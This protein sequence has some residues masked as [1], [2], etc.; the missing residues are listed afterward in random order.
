[1]KTGSLSERYLKKAIIKNIVKPDKKVE[2]GVAL[3]NDFSVSDIEDTL[4]TSDGVGLS[5]AI[6]FMKALNNFCC[7]FGTCLYAR[8][9]MMFPTTVKESELSRYMSIFQKLATQEGIQIVGGDSK[10]L[11]QID[12]PLFSVTLFGN[13]SDTYK[14]QKKEV[15]PGFDIVSV[16]ACGM[17]GTNLL[18]ETEKTKLQD[19]FAQS[20]LNQAE[21]EEKELSISKVCQTVK[22]ENLIQTGRICYA[23]D[24]SEGGIYQALW[25]VGEWINKGIM[26]ENQDIL[27][28][29]ETIEICEALD[30]NPY[31]IDG[32]GCLLLVCEKGRIVSDTLQKKGFEAKVI[33][34]VTQGKERLVTITESDI[35]KL[36]A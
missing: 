17:L 15:K 18:L 2:T 30:L 3:G 8:I 33:G 14:T 31:Q 27:I 23:H 4:V 25:Q 11:S 19:R 6:A 1:M 5:P 26:I 7:S 21:F 13:G 22:E 28:R 20:F 32:A 24:V 35:R 29:Q 36:E 10:V 34:K 9:V 12:S 16:G